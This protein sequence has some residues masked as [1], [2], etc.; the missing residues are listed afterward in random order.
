M[1]VNYPG[2]GIIQIPN[3]DELLNQQQINRD[4]LYDLNQFEIV[5][6][7]ESNL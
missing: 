3:S 7:R 1:D 2:L 5:S 6:K 4:A